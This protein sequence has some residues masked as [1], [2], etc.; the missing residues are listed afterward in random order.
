MPVV[1]VALYRRIEE[2]AGRPAGLLPS[3]VCDPRELLGRPDD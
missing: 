3:L 2:A 1:C